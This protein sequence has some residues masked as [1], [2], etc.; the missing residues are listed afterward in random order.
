MGDCITRT[1]KGRRPQDVAAQ[2]NWPAGTL[3]YTPTFTAV[4]LHDPCDKL[5]VYSS[6]DGEGVVVRAYRDGASVTSVYLDADAVTAMATD[7]A[8]RL[9]YVLAPKDAAGTPRLVPGERLSNGSQ[10]T[11]GEKLIVMQG[12]DLLGLPDGQIVTALYTTTAEAYVA[13]TK[14]DS[15]E[16]WGDVLKARFARAVPA[17]TPSSS[18]QAVVIDNLQADLRD[19]VA[20]RVAA[21]AKLSLVRL[22]FAALQDA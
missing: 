16:E 7:L 17:T 14:D 13:V 15:G 10:V 9:G 2:A 5:A 22:A 1:A 20:A 19:A 12:W 4:D 3:R 11:K 8:G 18:A 21:E 6:A